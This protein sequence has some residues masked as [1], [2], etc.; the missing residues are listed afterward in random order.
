MHEQHNIY[1]CD[2]FH[3][4]CSCPAYPSP[5]IK[6]IPRGK[7]EANL[8]RSISLLQNDSSADTQC[9]CIS[10]HL[11]WRKVHMYCVLAELSFWS[12]ECDRFKFALVFLLGSDKK[13]LLT[14]LKLN[15]SNN[16]NRNRL[17]NFILFDKYTYVI[18]IR[19]MYL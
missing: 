2:A 7:T 11:H 9:M 4:C 6:W 18:C 5:E 16:V 3:S 1:K 12:K 8:K 13:C 15:Y 17:I 14:G 19:Y 10:L